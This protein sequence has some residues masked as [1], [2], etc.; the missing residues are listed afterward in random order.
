MTVFPG[1]G[2]QSF[3]A[4][5]MAKVAQ[6][7]AEVI[8]AASL[9]VDIE[10][11]GGIDADTAPVAA[12]A[13]ANVFVAGSAIFGHDRPWEAAD[14]I[15]ASASRRRPPDG[16][17][18][19]TRPGRRRGG[20]I[21]GTWHALELAEAGFAVDHLEAEAAPDG[22]VGAQL[23]AG[24]GQRPAFGRGARGGAPGPPA[25]GGG[26]RRGARHRVPPDE[27]AHRR[28]RRPPTAVMEAFAAHPD[29]AARAISFL[30]PDEV[31]ACNPA[32]P[33]RHRRCAAL[34]ARTRSSSPAAPSGPCAPTSTARATERYRFHPGCRVVAA[35]P[36]ALIDTT[37]TRW[38]GD[39]VVAR[40]RRRLR[41]PARHR[42]PSAA[43]LRRVRLQM[44]ET[45]PFAA[46][47]TTSLADADTLRYYPAYESAPLGRLG[48]QDA[49]RG[50]RT[51][52]SCCWS[53]APTAG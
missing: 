5:V 1:F 11:D 32:V 14:A 38:E 6:V 22:R 19:T 8:D 10:V 51:T 53:S 45:A 30:E 43:R 42:R 44:L 46:T 50:R 20:G 16:H 26:R 29:A 47:L 21:V 41:P 49:G 2:G 17:G 37:G 39:L 23:R 7:R 15:R 34:H 40:H 4:D 48:E 27:L 3:M 52:C 25:L 24:L 31:R 13:G 28:Q 35:E 33:G 12:A 18:V 36:H 9:A